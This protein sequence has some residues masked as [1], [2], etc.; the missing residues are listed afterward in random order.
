[1]EKWERTHVENLGIYQWSMLTPCFEKSLDVN[2]YD[3]E[4]NCILPFV[5]DEERSE[6][7]NE[8]GF[9][10]VWEIE[11]HPAHH[12]LYAGPNPQVRFASLEASCTKTNAFR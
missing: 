7:N 8:G 4:D 5:K 6:K 9:S 10:F 2:H 3:L 11:I 12:D 1:M